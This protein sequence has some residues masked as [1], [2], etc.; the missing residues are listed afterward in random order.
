[1]YSGL[2]QLEAGDSWRERLLIPIIPVFPREAREDLDLL[3]YIVVL[4]ISLAELLHQ[5]P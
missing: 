2:L 1:M 5:V 3:Q 4:K